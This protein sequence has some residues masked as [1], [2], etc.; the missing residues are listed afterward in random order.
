MGSTESS[1]HEGSST[2]STTTPTVTALLAL[3]DWQALPP[4]TRQT[5]RTL[6]PLMQ[7]GCSQSEIAKRLSLPEA[8]V[9]AMRR[10]MR[11]AIVDQC[12]ARLDE[13]EPRVRALVEQ[14]R[15]A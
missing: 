8:R 9:A 6:G 3:I 2:T 15:A 14:L 12:H 5:I 11:D 1:T 13:L 10:E 4:E 7:E